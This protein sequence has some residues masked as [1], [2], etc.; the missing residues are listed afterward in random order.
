MFVDLAT[1]ESDSS[2]PPA[3]LQVSASSAAAPP[4]SASPSPNPLE[5]TSPDMFA[6]SA[7]HV[8]IEPTSDSSRPPSRF[9]VSAYK[10]PGPNYHRRQ[11]EEEVEKEMS[12]EMRTRTGARPKKKMKLYITS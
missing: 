2:R 12:E 8:P 11:T 1:Y 6:D 4:E 9:P 10:P 3:M 7:T 5:E